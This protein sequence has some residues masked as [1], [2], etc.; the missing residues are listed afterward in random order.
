M[1]ARAAA[2]LLA[3]AAWAAGAKPVGAERLPARR[4]T[5]SDGL[6]HDR[7][8]CIVQDSRGFLWLCTPLGLSRFDGYAFTT[9]STEHGLPGDSVE[10]LVEE[11][12]GRYWVET[13]GGGLC[14]FD[15]AA[16]RCTPQPLG[17]PASVN[18]L[19]RDRD[20]RVLVARGAGILR[21]EDGTLREV[22]TVAG[23]GPAPRVYTARAAPDG[24]LW[25]GTSGGLVELRPDGSTRR[26]ALRAGT[27][28]RAVGVVALDAAGRLWLAS[29]DGLYV[30]PPPPPDGS[31]LRVR[32][33]D[34]RAFA[35]NGPAP[36]EAV[37]VRG[38]PGADAVNLGDLIDVRPTSD[39]H[40]WIGTLVGGLTEFDG[41]RFRT[42]AP[43][44]GLARVG[45]RSLG[46]DRQ[47]NLWVG[48]EAS[49]AFKVSR[50]GFRT[51]DESDGLRGDRISSIFEDRAGRLLV[52]TTDGFLNAFDG[53][54]FTA[55]RPRV[56]DRFAQLRARNTLQDR[57]GDWWIRSRAGLYRF[58]GP[59]LTGVERTAAAVF[60]R[61]DGLAADNVGTLLEDR[62]G[63]LWVASSTPAG[64]TVQV[65]DPRT[66]TARTVAADAA[67]G[68][69]ALP[70]LTAEDARGAVWI[71]FASGE[72]LRVDERGTTRLTVEGTPPREV[73]ALHFDAA[74]RLWIAHSGGPVLRSDAPDAPAPR[75]A[76]AWFGRSANCLTEDAQGRVY[77]GS[78][79]GV[80]RWD[81]GTGRVRQFT[82]ADG[83]AQNEMKAA[84]RDRRGRLWF[85]TIQGLSS[86]DPRPDPPDAATD[87]WVT[88]VRVAGE[89]RAV[90]AVGEASVTGLVVPPD[91]N[92]LQVEFVGLAFGSGER[93]R[94]EY[95]LDGPGREWSA[96]RP[97]R[98]V[99]FAQLSPGEHVFEVRA[100]NSEGLASA[101]PATV[102]FRV[103][104]PFWRRGWFAAGVLCAV[105]A[106]AFQWHRRRLA[107]LLEMERM[108]T[109]IASD[110]HD[111]IGSTLS[112]ISI[113]GAV[114]QARAGRLGP[115]AA[116]PVSL[117]GRLARES[118]DGLSDIVWAINPRHDH[119]SNLAHRM[120]RLADDLLS[121]QGVPFSFDVE[122]ADPE[123]VL[124]AGVRRQVFLVFKEALNNVV[125][126]AACTRVAV[127]LRVERGTLTL[128]V[129]DDGR[130]FDPATVR[131]GEGLASLRQRASAL[132]GTLAVTAEAGTSVVLTVPCG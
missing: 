87:V 92:H 97:E 72:V 43:P 19:G 84:Y 32:D 26:H 33:V 126:H 46:E 66:R 82:S 37:R 74:G 17:D 104:A 107:H 41:V 42:H 9:Y 53:A 11:K 73:T 10:R 40:V 61:A 103:I 69:A 95:R 125:R 127:T 3:L 30:A 16:S 76:Y 99:N 86:L 1:S 98:A 15:A 45:V 50:G 31:A 131:P 121:A 8:K 58:A 96:P 28:G 128:A 88:A 5:A 100:V 2:V 48:T 67:S 117:M 111:D 115:E 65:F 39:G 13:N 22:A 81:P 62:R 35:A 105:G 75:A 36:G 114:V 89:S 51:Y 80:E 108:R 119:L 4:Y 14:L 112:Q 122:G 23:L 109:R 129:I 38:V 102:S 60:G 34:A 90:S 27:P 113:L 78:L 71:G 7:V 12:E 18:L 123:H 83:L 130:G 91:R 44:V 94:Y 116:E 106:L 77:V 79:R 110:L 124:G 132:G 120:R 63:R 49:G 52:S 68:R 20:G 101:R 70:V 118:M 29:A 57:A 59:A 24:R 56:P 93:L 54:R 64:A 47:G 85:G 21:V 25:L 55:V 6:A